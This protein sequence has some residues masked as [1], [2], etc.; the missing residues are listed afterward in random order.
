MPSNK[1][2][3]QVNDLLARLEDAQGAVL[4]DYKG[5][6]HKQ[7]EELR[8]KLEESG[9]KLRVTK[10]TLLSIAISRKYKAIDNSLLA[11]HYRNPTAT[12]FLGDNYVTDLKTIMEFVKA[13]ELPT[14][15]G[16]VINDVYYD[17]AQIVALSK[18][19]TYDELI[20][21]LI[22]QIQAPLRG[23][24][25]VLQGPSRQLVNVINQVS[26]KGGE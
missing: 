17:E 25:T 21:M 6:E 16:G 8:N 14:V 11:D 1:N 12:V 4:L 26:I 2:I 10:N 18:L 15:K 13:N 3:E 5:L 22:G 24:I 19:P 20:S 9:S 23:L 7:L